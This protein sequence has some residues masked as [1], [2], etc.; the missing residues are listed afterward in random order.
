MQNFGLV[1]ISHKI[2]NR[3]FYMLLLETREN[4]Y[5]SL[6]QKPHLIFKC[7]KSGFEFDAINKI[8]PAARCTNPVPRISIG[9][10]EKVTV[11]IGMF[12]SSW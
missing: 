3:M 9:Q 1:R 5:G 2:N 6:L 7:D 4:D 11:S 8:V 10:H 12:V